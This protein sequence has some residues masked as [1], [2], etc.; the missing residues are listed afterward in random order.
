MR[1][2]LVLTMGMI[3]PVASAETVD[4]LKGIFAHPPREYST[5]PLWVWNDLISEDQIRSTMSDLAA[6]DVKQV[7]VHPRPGLMTPYLS[8]DWFRLWDIALQE[9]ERLDMNVWIYDENSYPSGFAGGFV[10]EAMPESRALGMDRRKLTLPAEIAEPVL[11]VFSTDPAHPEDLTESYRLGALPE[12]EYNVIVE[13][14]TPTSPWYGGTF[15]VDLIRPGVTQK[16]LEIT[17][18]AYKEHIGGQFGKRVPGVFTDEPHLASAPGLHW[19]PDLPEQFQKRWGY[20][21]RAQW[22]SLWE[23]V[24]DWRRVRHDYYQTLLELFIDRWAKPYFEYCDA[25]KL[26]FTGHYWEHGWPETRT[27]PDN[28]AMYAWHQRPA[29]DTLFNQYDEGP[30]AQFGNVR[31]VLELCS[32]ANQSGWRRTLCEAYGG[33][34]WDV[35]FEDLKRIGDWL[36]VLGVNTVNEHLSQITNRGARKADYPPSFSYHA[37]WFENYHVMARY[38]TRLS[39]AMSHGEQINEILLLE[40]TSTAWMYQGDKETLA[41]LGDSFQGLVTTL[42]KAQIEFDLGSED[43]IARQGAAKDKRFVVGQ[44]AYSTVIIPHLM[45][46]MNEATVLLL[47]EFL[48]QGGTIL[49]T[50]DAPPARV[51]GQ[52]SG[53]AAA[54]A[55]LPGWKTLPAESLVSALDSRMDSGFRVTRTEDDPGI[56]YH[57]RRQFEDGDLVLLVN[58]SIDHATAGAISARAKG[59]EVWDVEGGGPAQVY[60]FAQSNGGLTTSFSIPP[61]GSLLLF[62]ADTESKSTVLAENTQWRPIPGKEENTI[63]RDSLN[64]LTLD[65]VDI[66]AGGET[67]Q[68]LYFYQAAERVFRAHG[69]DQ[70]P[71]DHAVQ[72]RDQLISKTFPADSGFEAAYHFEIKGEVPAELYF[73]LERAD[74]YMITCN[75]Q[76]V[77]LTPGAWWLDRSFHKMDIQQLAKTGVNDLVIRAQPFT[78]FHELEPAYLL[79]AFALESVEKG[80]AISGEVPLDY[81]PWKA[82][83]LPLYGDTVS[84]TQRFVLA[85]DP[86]GASFKVQLP[87]WRGSVAKVTVNGGE[88][89]FIWHA[90]WEC[91]VTTGLRPGENEITVTVYGTPKNPLGPHHGD[92]PLGFAGP[93][94]FRKGPIPG[95]PPGA[96]YHTLDY[97]LF[98]PFVLLS[99]ASAAT[100]S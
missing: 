39:A 97:G 5:G 8:A 75:G 62:F 35:R 88:A 9:A 22:L 13:T 53:E 18:D 50:A 24:G 64:V 89:G 51:D 68:D 91:P 44:R 38:F 100:A 83:G 60:P 40:P 49:C 76:P 55:A 37:P 93:G 17:M 63:R 86:G 2:F 78:M 77:G 52:E 29:I 25:N 15:F 92:P 94:S 74:L 54:L 72:L 61:C 90:P 3:V 65:Y 12:G 81:G 98:S 14:L 46:N 4:S 21:L 26:E 69:M 57:H 19:T 27:A 95:P 33:S 66:T 34:G 6:Q 99:S 11:A 28:M 82:Q 45:E 87:E 41:V 23:P 84:Y 56:L 71:W 31:A 20:D 58:T 48:V 70:N 30:H 80:F 16:F 32:A 43:I 10:P 59:V 73:V 67:Q 85:G 79:G 42:A 36:L 1:L 47:K 96:Q 7:W